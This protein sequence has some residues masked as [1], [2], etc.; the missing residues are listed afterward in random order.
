MQTLST[1]LRHEPGG[2]DQRT[3]LCARVKVPGSGTRLLGRS[4]L[5]WHALSV[6]LSVFV[7]LRKPMTV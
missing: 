7:F 1:Q 3:G 5:P 4:P 6:V 2:R